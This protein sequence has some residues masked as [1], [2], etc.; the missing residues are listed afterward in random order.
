[1]LTLVAV[2]P[3]PQAPPLRARGWPA[4]AKL[5]ATLPSAHQMTA[6]PQP[7]RWRSSQRRPQLQRQWRR[8][9]GPRRGAVRPRAPTRLR[10]SS[11]ADLG[12]RQVSALW[13]SRRSRPS[14]ACSV[15]RAD[16]QRCGESQTGL[17]VSNSSCPPRA[18]QHRRWPGMAGILGGWVARRAG[19]E[20]GEGM[21]T[22]VFSAPPDMPT[23]GHAATAANLRRA[24]LGLAVQVKTRM[25]VESELKGTRDVADAPEVRHAG[26]VALRAGPPPRA[27]RRALPLGLLTGY[28]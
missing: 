25:E 17:T 13:A 26:R 28:K 4:T 15:P 21:H 5:P 16:S 6:S 24:A 2:R 27:A 19:K 8:H 14:R 11:H 23:G 10:P 1:M 20:Q 22:S 9:S 7:L 3:A 18:P 12:E